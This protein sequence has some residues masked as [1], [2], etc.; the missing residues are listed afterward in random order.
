VLLEV[1]IGALRMSGRE[2]AR[3]VLRG[4]YARA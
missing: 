2:R 4:G 3:G 1:G